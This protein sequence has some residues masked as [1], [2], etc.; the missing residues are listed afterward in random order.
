MNPSLPTEQS[1]PSEVQTVRSAGLS[2]G[3]GIA[4]TGLF[5]IAALLTIFLCILN[6]TDLLTL[7][8]A[9]RAARA[10]NPDPAMGELFILAITLSPLALSYLIS[11]KIIE[12]A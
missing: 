12:K 11:T 3:S 7:N 6:Y 2:I 8:S 4:I 1:T 9:N 10:D 5:L